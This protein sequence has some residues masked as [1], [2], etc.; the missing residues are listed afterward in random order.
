VIEIK[1]A[2]SPE[3]RRAVVAQ[4]LTYAAYLR[5]LDL[6]V[7]EREILGGHLQKRGYTSLASAVAANDQEGAFDEHAFATE[8]AASLADGRFRLVLVLD[9]APQEL[10]RL[11]GYLEAVAD[12]LV[13]DLVT[14]ASFEIAGT[15]VVVPQRVDPERTA[16]RT[17]T[18][19]PSSA[20]PG[21]RL[22]EGAGDF[23]ATIDD[24]AE[25]QQALL[26]RL[27]EWAKELERERLVNLWTYHG[28]SSM[29]TL[30]P[31]L[32]PENVGLVTIYNERRPNGA[33]L[34]F[35]RSVIIRRAPTSL[36]RIEHLAAPAKV[37]QGT[38]TRQISDDLLTAL[39]EAYREAASGY[40]QLEGAKG[41]TAQ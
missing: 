5:G 23:E 28:I 21:G 34:Q 6:S 30:L 24:A 10:V 13:I 33:Y 39:T 19:Q 3:A 35:W 17:A 38:T 11:V 41:D 40:V 4:V 20:A 22:V 37:G 16:T 18:V 32:Q 27:T 9:A 7:L 29:V 14:V 15:Q 8:L 31:R 12:K 26:R 25:D 2:K 1:L 36:P